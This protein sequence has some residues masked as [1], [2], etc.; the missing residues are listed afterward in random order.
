M[1]EF[2]EVGNK[3]KISAQF[4][5]NEKH[6]DIGC[7]FYYNYNNNNIIC[8]SVLDVKRENCLTT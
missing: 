4:F 1:H 5:Q 2:I 7:E 6:F 8:F 3:C